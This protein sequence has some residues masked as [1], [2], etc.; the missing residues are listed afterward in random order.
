MNLR[1][2][3]RGA[4]ALAVA[5]LA[6]C[7]DDIT[8]VPTAADAE[9]ASSRGG[10]AVADQYIVVFKNGVSDAPGLARQL[11]EAHGGTLRHTYRHALQGFAATLPAAA[12]E[13]LRNNP[14]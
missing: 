13:A 2:L 8:T 14:N 3:A 4:A 10:A 7:S 11:T 12:A 5:A 9:A 6:A 1:H